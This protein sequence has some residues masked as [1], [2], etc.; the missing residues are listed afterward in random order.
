MPNE[1]QEGLDGAQKESSANDSARTSASM[2]ELFSGDLESPDGDESNGS[3]PPKADPAPATKETETPPPAQAEGAD[4]S[5]SESGDSDASIFSDLEKDIP[6]ELKAKAENV[7]KKF[8]A[9]LTR[10]TQELAEKG[11]QYTQEIDTLKKNQITPKL[12]EDYG[13]MY[14]YYKEIVDNPRAGLLKLASQFGV[15]FGPS[16]DPSEA[17][18]TTKEITSEELDSKE[19]VAKFVAQEIHKAVSKVR[20]EEVKPLQERWASQDEHETRAKHVNV[21]ARA[22]ESMYGEE[23][24]LTEDKTQVSDEGKAAMLAVLSGKFPGPDGMKNAFNA[25]IANKIRSTAQEKIRAIEAENAALKSNLA[26]A[27]NIPGG[28]KKTT[29]TAPSAPGNFWGDLSKESLS[30]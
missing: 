24:F 11:R 12:Q 1:T 30:G 7:K 18:P 26:G 16:Q 8:Q 2:D 3:E 29:T 19:A 27:T 13:K 22:V 6:E 10:K 9:V 23:G 14:G 20:D 25:I 5:I 17:T 28:T 4:K 21:G 15:T